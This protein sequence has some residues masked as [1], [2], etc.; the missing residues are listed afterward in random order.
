[1]YVTL[2]GTDPRASEGRLNPSAQIYTGPIVIPDTTQIK[3]RA[4]VDETWSAL[5]QATFVTRDIEHSL[6]IS[7]M[8]PC[9]LDPAA[10]YLEF[11]NI[12]TEPINLAQVRLS[13]AV[14]FI[15]PAMTLA[16]DG[17]VLVVQNTDVFEARYGTGLPVAGE[18]SGVLSP[19]GERLVLKDP[20]GQVIHDFTY[21]TAWYDITRSQDF[22]LT[23]RPEVLNDQNSQSVYGDAL[24]WRPS[25]VQ[26]GS[27]G[28]DEIIQPAWPGSIIITEILSHSH[29]IASDW[30]ELYNTTD[31]A[32]HV[33]GWFLSDDPQVPQK[34]EIA[35]GTLIEPKGYLV[36]YEVQQFGNP[37]D[38]GAHEP[39]ALSEN[40]E[41][42]YVFSGLD[43][44]LTGFT[45]EE[46]FGASL[47]GVPFGL[48]LKSTDTDN[49]VAMSEPTP[50]QAN[51][52]PLV[53]PVVISEIMYHPAGDE[54]AEYV[55]LVNISDDMV[56]LFDP[57][58][59][60]PWR[61]QDNPD[62]SGIDLAFPLN[63]GLVL[64]PGERVVLVMDKTAFYKSYNVPASV[65]VLQWPKGKLSNSGDKIQLD[66][67][68]DVDLD[69]LRY[70]IRVDRVNYSDGSHPDTSGVD[71]WP[72][73]PDGRGWSLQRVALDAYGNDPVNW[74]AGMPTPGW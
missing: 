24:S 53:G 51:A 62:G 3:A 23:V 42:L 29:D 8:M 64:H 39:F 44:A 38:P 2:D 56:A 45:V 65:T 59:Y 30:I 25:H 50:G 43:G 27:P 54:D 5:S 46:T 63:P 72:A 52:D 1:V 57:I 4:W 9:P 66:Q 60:L 40:G 28:T 13:E 12:G 70:W 26:A 17:H 20:I 68:G 49:F 67:P 16:P 18:Y 35:Y 10:A 48:Y 14:R 36:L 73:G 7:E 33:G 32:M 55:E 22:S 15:F 74:Q 61:F 47:T 21:E 6:R 31:E 37:F 11:K 71:L 69:G 58:E 19:E 34:Y 41:M